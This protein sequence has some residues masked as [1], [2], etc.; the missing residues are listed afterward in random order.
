MDG[1]LFAVITKIN[2]LTNYPK[3]N[4]IQ[5]D[6]ELIRVVLT[7]GEKIRGW[8]C[9]FGHISLLILFFIILSPP[10]IILISF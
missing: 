7:N 8:N 5:T 6:F 10:E 2:E 9:P 1:Q 4:I 3:V